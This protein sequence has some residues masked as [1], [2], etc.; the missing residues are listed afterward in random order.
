MTAPL[1]GDS[2]AIEESSSVRKVI[3]ELAR[4]EGRDEELYDACAVLGRLLAECGGSPTLCALTLDHA[5]QALGAL[6]SPWLV[7]A[8]A[9]L[10]EGYT[11]ALRERARLAGLAAWDFPACAVRVDNA[12]V[13]IAAGLPSDDEESI[14]TW[15]ARTANA[16]ARAGYRRAL[17]SGPERCRG[18]LSEA[19]GVAGISCVVLPDLAV[20]APSSVPGRT[21]SSG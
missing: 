20:Q 7:A 12:T 15:A 17:A 19:L 10:V 4:H 1:P 13:A 18:A 14:A 8:R 21:R 2:R 6:E 3:V 9:A 5:A 16:V 11:R